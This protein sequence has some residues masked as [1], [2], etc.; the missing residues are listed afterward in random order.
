ML[1]YMASCGSTTCDKFDARTARWF[2]IQQ[3]GRSSPGGNWAQQD[4][5]NGAPAQVTLPA[6]IAPGNY[7]IRHEI[8]ALHLAN[9]MG[10][11]EFYP[12]CSQLTVTG[13]GTGVP[14]DSEL[15]S[16]PGAYSDTDPGIYTQDAFNTDPSYVYPFPGPQIAAFVNEGPAPAGDSASNSTATP[17]ATSSSPSSTGV[18]GATSS[19]SSGGCRLRKRAAAVNRPRHFSRIMRDLHLHHS[20]IH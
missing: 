8:I 3:V 17:S 10:G 11:A 6:N 15:V 20:G 14:K 7:L 2:K 19:G 4:L 18:S 16:L 5:M 12:S 13:T 1:T 9:T